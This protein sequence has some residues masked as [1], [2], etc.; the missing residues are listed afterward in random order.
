MGG[1]GLLANLAVAATS[2]VVVLGLVEAGARLGYPE[3][4]YHFPA[5]MFVLDDELRHRLA[6]GFSGRLRDDE[7][8]TLG[9]S[10]SSCVSNSRV[11]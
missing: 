2:C 7:F 5:G 8:D 6:P 11:T 10:A 4:G 1:R 3:H 9:L